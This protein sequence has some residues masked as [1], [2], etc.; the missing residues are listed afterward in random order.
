ML[1]VLFLWPLE[2][3]HVQTFCFLLYTSYSLNP[4]SA[5]HTPGLE[6]G[7]NKALNVT[8]GY[9]EILLASCRMAEGS[10]GLYEYRRGLMSYRQSGPMFL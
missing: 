2:D 5:T 1:V 8:E 3:I 9:L 7:R 10:I 4:A 6:Q